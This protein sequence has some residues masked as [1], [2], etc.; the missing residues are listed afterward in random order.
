MD[1]SERDFADNRKVKKGAE[2]DGPAYVH[3]LSPCPIGWRSAPEIS[4]NIARLA[5]Q[6]GVFPLFEIET[7]KYKLN[8]IPTTLKPVQEYLKLQGRFKHLTAETTKHIQERIE[9][10]W[11]ELKRKVDAQRQLS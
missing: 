1:A 7:G 11:V 3:I 4:V 10:E 9:L 8:V 5:V 2:I 6:T